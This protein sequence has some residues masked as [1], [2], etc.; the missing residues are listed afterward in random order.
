MSAVHA[1]KHNSAS[2]MVSN[3]R[4]SLQQ[5]KHSHSEE[6]LGN[7]ILPPPGSMESNSFSAC[8]LHDVKSLQGLA[9]SKA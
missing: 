8:S 6:I 9:R 7:E 2:N 5:R 4:D 3:S 1:Q